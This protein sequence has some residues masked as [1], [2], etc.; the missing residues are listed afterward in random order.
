MVT[1]VSDARKLPPVAEIAVAAMSLIVIGG[2]TLASRLPHPAP[3]PV[4][5]ALLAAAAA[6][7]AVDV[8]L[9]T[10]LRD[11]A[12]PLFFL[13]AKWTLLAYSVMYG[14][15]EFTFVYDHVT[16]STLAVLTLMLAV[17]AVDIPILFGFS[18]ARYA[19]PAPAKAGGQQVTS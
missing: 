18:V 2:I 13:V 6:L 4:L 7:V 11:F 16:G 10:R 9:L 19:T 3:L 5:I 14:I 1:Q 8:V 15:L 17:F 12:W